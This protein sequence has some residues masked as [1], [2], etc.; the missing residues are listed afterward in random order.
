MTFMVSPIK[1][2]MHAISDL[3]LSNK[4][5][6]NKIVELDTNDSSESFDKSGNHVDI[7]INTIVSMIG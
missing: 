3:V 6:A 5:N 1:D 4:T 7:D 2:L